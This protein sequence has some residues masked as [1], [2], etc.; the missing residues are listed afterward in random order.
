MEDYGVLNYM[1]YLIGTILIILLPGPNS[2]YV[3]AISAQKGIKS[4]WAA[5]CG[6]FVGDAIL[7]LATAAGAVTLLNTYPLLF[8]VVQYAGAAYLS[9]IGLR[10]LLSALATWKLRNSLSDALEIE[11]QKEIPKSAP[12]TKALIV[13]L[14][15]PKAI[16]FFI[17]FFV[18]F[19]DP[20]YAEP[21]VP[22]FVLAVT[23]QICSALY[24]A[25]VI[26]GG[27]YLAASFRKRRRLSAVTTATT[28]AAFMGF[29]AKL[30]T[31]TMAS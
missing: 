6:V 15:N 1:T 28:G 13:S 3:L 2:L 19:V 14:L 25:T 23:L 9:Y 8:H 29:A 30:A 27:N 5:A 20:T 31:S 7:M 12:F 18:Q 21:A 10:L 4:G 11:A 22:F 17:S 24:L 16:L 26:Y